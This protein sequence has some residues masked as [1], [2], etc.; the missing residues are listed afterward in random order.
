V[1][2]TIVAVAAVFLLCLGAPRVRAA[3]QRLTLLD[4][5]SGAGTS[6][7]VP[8]ASMTDLYKATDA[9]VALPPIPA[10]WQCTGPFIVT[11]AL[12][13]EYSSSAPVD[14]RM[15]QALLFIGDAAGPN[16]TRLIANL[17]FNMT[18]YDPSF[19]HVPTCPDTVTTE[20]T[21]S[22]PLFSNVP[23]LRSTTTGTNQYFWFQIYGIAPLNYNATTRTGN[24]VRW[25]ILANAISSTL[26]ITRPP[27]PTS[28]VRD[29]NNYYGQ[30]WVNWTSLRRWEETYSA[31]PP[32]ALDTVSTS[33]L[34]ARI[35][36]DGCATTLAVPS[37]VLVPPVPVTQQTPSPVPQPLP[38]LSPSPDGVVIADAPSSIADAPSPAPVPTS[39]DPLATPS[40]ALSTGALAGIIIA[41]IVLF[42]PLMV[43][44]YF[45]VRAIRRRIRFANNKMTFRESL[46]EHAE[47]VPGGGGGGGGGADDA[48]SLYYMRNGQPAGTDDAGLDTSSA[49][50][51]AKKS[52][53]PHTSPLQ[54]RGASEEETATLVSLDT[55]S[56]TQPP[57]ARSKGLSSSVSSAWIPSEDVMFDV[58]VSKDTPAASLHKRRGSGAFI[59]SE[60]DS[61]SRSGHGTPRNVV[62]VADEDDLDEDGD[63]SGSSAGSAH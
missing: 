56:V 53:K 5:L 42:C 8:T 35:E 15:F 45:A 44:L 28:R 40:N 62:Q 29:R 63:G 10:G 61:E 46:A 48:V 24:R 31:T 58:S 22:L 26:N 50:E 54:R 32:A 57:V 12:C 60:E 34:R 11:P 30:S 23:V 37:P 4:T 13:A 1:S 47:S 39:S 36:L 9:V 27:T 21:L 52:K 14:I 49:Q 19:R 7:A 43:G 2:L 59:S 25:S 55:G 3:S 16:S 33:M 18:F 51:R 6:D 20:L 41:S 17:R 38:P